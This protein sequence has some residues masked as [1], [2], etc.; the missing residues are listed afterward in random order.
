MFFHCLAVIYVPVYGC[1]VK[2]LLM[3]F[4]RE[5]KKQTEVGRVVKFYEEMGKSEMKTTKNE[6]CVH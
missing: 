1:V 2:V 5:K 3:C 6:S 4:W